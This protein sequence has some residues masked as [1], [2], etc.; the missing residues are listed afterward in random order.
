MSER[1]P[2]CFSKHAPPALIQADGDRYHIQCET[3]GRFD[4]SGTVMTTMP[5]SS[6]MTVLQR[7]ALSHR[8]RRSA[9]AN[10]VPPFLSTHALD[11]FLENPALPTPAEQAT[12]AV[13]SIG[14][15]VRRSGEK[16]EHLPSGFYAII[17][18]AS[19]AMAADIVRQLE[20]RGIVQ[21][22]VVD[23]DDGV[24][25]LDVDLTLSGWERYDAELRGRVSAGHGFLALKFGDTP[26][27]AFV[28]DV[29]KPSVK[30]GVGFDLFDMRDIAR[31][32]LIDNI[33][34]AQICD[35]AFAIVDLTHDNA[36][37]YWEAGYAEGLG[38]PVIYICEKSKF[39]AVKT[40]FDT[41]HSTTIP[42]DDKSPDTFSKELVATLRRSL[43]LFG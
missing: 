25:F 29:V 8:L 31:A 23:S 4:V 18:S 15:E 41:N 22:A 43:N 32:G 40:H 9:A 30:R 11:Q 27:D 1:C 10:N 14:E 20:R 13:R 38:K 6:V 3:C 26:L 2:V 28:A 16:L 37:A 35:A 7:A 24:E 34:R 36:G 39:D 21:G 33:M 5:S 19:P 12:N 17:G 42:W